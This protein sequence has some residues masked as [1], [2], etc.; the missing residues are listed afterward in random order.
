MTTTERI[1]TLEEHLKKLD[2]Q[3]E[4]ASSQETRNSALQSKS[5]ALLALVM[6]Y[7]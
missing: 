2:E 7:K 1:V 5:I 3:Y 4:L 6:E